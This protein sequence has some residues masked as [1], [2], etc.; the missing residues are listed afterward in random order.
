[1]KKI[2][3]R[4]N[5]LLSHKSNS[6]KRKYFL[7]SKFSDTNIKSNKSM[8]EEF[9]C[10]AKA[11]NISDG[12]FP[13]EDSIINLFERQIVSETKSIKLA[14]KLSGNILKETNLKL[15]KDIDTKNEAINSLLD[16]IN[17]NSKK[18]NN[19]LEETLNKS[20]II[21]KPILSESYKKG[22]VVDLTNIDFIDQNIDYDLEEPADED[23]SV[24]AGEKFEDLKDDD[25]EIEYKD[26]DIIASFG[27]K[28]PRSF[29]KKDFTA[30]FN[31]DDDVNYHEKI[32]RILKNL[33][34]DLTPEEQEELKSIRT[35]A[36]GSP[37]RSA[38]DK[39]DK[40]AA[41]AISKM[42]LEA[43]KKYFVIE[44]M[45]RMLSVQT[46][47]LRFLG[48]NEKQKQVHLSKLS[49]AS[50]Q[51]LSDEERRSKTKD[52]ED[53]E[54]ESRRYLSGSSEYVDDVARFS[55]SKDDDS[56]YTKVSTHK[57]KRSSRSGLMSQQEINSFDNEIQQ[58]LFKHDFD[59]TDPE[60]KLD[61]LLEIAKRLFNDSLKF[62]QMISDMSLMFDEFHPS[63]RINPMSQSEFEQYRDENERIDREIE[64]E[65]RTSLEQTDDVPVI[66]V[67]DA[68]FSVL[69]E[70]VTDMTELEWQEHQSE[71]DECRKRLNQLNKKLE[72][73]KPNIFAEFETD[74]NGNV[75]IE[76]L[77]DIPAEGLTQ[78]EIDE[79][80]DLVT[81]LSKD[82]KVTM[83]SLDQK[84]LFYD[85]LYRNAAAT[86][87]D[88]VKFMRRFGLDKK[89][90]PQKY[91][92]IGMQ[93]FG[94]LTGTSGPR[95]YALKA[96]TKGNYYSL[97]LDEKSE[98][99]S[100]LAT[101]WFDTLTELDLVYDEAFK[102]P[103]EPNMPKLVR[104]FDE[105]QRYISKSGF[106]K[107]FD[108]SGDESEKE[109]VREKIN[110]AYRYAGSELNKE[111]YDLIKRLEK[112]DPQFKRY[113][114]LDVLTS[115]ASSFRIYA[116]T[117]L[118]EFYAKHVWG[119]IEKDLYI[120]TRNYFNLNTKGSKI[121]TRLSR[122]TNISA[123][124]DLKRGFEYVITSLGNTDWSKVTQKDLYVG[125]NGSFEQPAIGDR[126]TAMPS[127]Q[128][129]SRVI[130]GV[131][132]DLG[133]TGRVKLLD[134]KH[135]VV[136]RDLTKEEGSELFDPIVYLA[137]LRT[138][139]PKDGSAYKQ[140]EDESTED[141]QRRYLLGEINNKGDFVNRV[142]SFNKLAREKGLEEIKSPDGSD[143]GKKDVEAL[144]DD[145][146]NPN[147]IIGSVKS[148]IK[149]MTSGV[150]NEFITFLSNYSKDRHEQI[151]VNSL[152]IS[153]VLRKGANP[154]NIEIF[155]AVG[156][157]TYEG[158]KKYKQEFAA[159]LTSKDFAEFLADEIGGLSV[160][161]PSK[162][163]AKP[164]SVTGDYTL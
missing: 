68:A 124:R 1:M 133:T 105:M 47:T 103:D 96:W 136:K 115:G 139:L 106:K 152:A 31:L 134:K 10:Y 163:G 74:I 48:L 54:K 13:T 17:L 19:K 150:S 86:P 40:L 39:V 112:D 37:V 99:Y 41:Y 24:I 141:Y 26:S 143:F 162:V 164:D 90:G 72:A 46:G 125:V 14:S 64:D 107:Y 101:K 95:Q 151:I 155:K 4:V 130:D 51:E 108:D 23:L 132:G 123:S 149:L 29:T 35:M 113:A 63:P 44:K 85:A 70:P 138:G 16:T 58:L 50:S 43:R 121:G 56:V 45:Y 88:F 59:L 42:P 25:V 159:Q 80:V 66:K 20:I 30:M 161:S 79:Y 93:S 137:M 156:K 157:D 52:I 153:S 144:L 73:T 98:I 91:S 32:N 76:D 78:E 8:L 127:S 135:A 110:A 9:K 2:K 154:M 3:N 7:L 36:K 129:T 131:F 60:L 104:F 34:R 12:L 61:S 81:K 122:P 69:N 21:K 147:G 89:E 119:S 102:R 128:L 6:Y 100:E 15:N 158:F 55:R 11:L 57:S 160:T 27:G 62:R 75:I 28:D 67:R 120:A 111:F 33:N 18:L 142:R 38:Q 140:E 53:Q 126:F 83:I 92:E 65:A 148:R 97:S 146:F 114:I 87:E 145:M 71:M 49:Q 117:M 5:K 22:N 94:K 77:E 118:K 82:M 84:G 116:T 109:Q